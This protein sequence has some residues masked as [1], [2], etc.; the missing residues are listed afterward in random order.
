MTQASQGCDR[1]CGVLIASTSPGAITHFKVKFMSRA[2]GT[3]TGHSGLRFEVKCLTYSFMLEEA[4][5]GNDITCQL[6]QDY[7]N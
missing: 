2:L 4:Y 1:P 7:G 5:Q 6:L 3:D